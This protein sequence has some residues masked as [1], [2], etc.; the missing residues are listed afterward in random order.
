MGESHVTVT[1]RP[2]PFIICPFDF[3]IL[4]IFSIKREVADTRP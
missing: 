1:S 4:L 2:S 3:G